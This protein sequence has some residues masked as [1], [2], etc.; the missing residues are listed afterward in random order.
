MGKSTE[1]GDE[2]IRV[3][4]G[5]SPPVTSLVCAHACTRGV[6]WEDLDPDGPA[7]ISKEKK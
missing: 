4:V 6:D 2:K 3:Q 5:L 1:F 7:K